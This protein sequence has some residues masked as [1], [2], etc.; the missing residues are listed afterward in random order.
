MKLQGK[1]AIVTGAAQGIGRQYA[2]RFAREG[3]AVMV[4]DLREQQAQQVAGEIVSAGGRARAVKA[5]VT[6]EQEMGELAKLTVAE[7]GRID[8]IINNAATYYDYNFADE[9]LEYGRKIMEVNLFSIIVTSR[10]VFPYMKAQRGGSIIN[11]S[12]TASY[13]FQ[14]PSDI[15]L[16]SVPVSF[17][18]LAKSGVIYLTKSMARSLGRY[19]I[20]VNA[21]APE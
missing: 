12:S 7:M 11:I 6:S 2:L 10:A 5:D 3:A 13:P 16:Q 14:I 8:A 15:D 18:G 20:R 19:N 17:Y 9:S 4:V 21:I 1:V